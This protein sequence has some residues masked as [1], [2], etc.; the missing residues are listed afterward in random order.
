MLAMIANEANCLKERGNE[1]YQSNCLKKVDRR[2]WMK[3]DDFWRKEAF[4]VVS[5][6]VINF[7]CISY[8]DEDN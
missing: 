6:H 8:N 5:I 7:V 1:F 2:H 3:L 4:Q